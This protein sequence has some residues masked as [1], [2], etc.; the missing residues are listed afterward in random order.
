MNTSTLIR[1]A[2][3]LLPAAAKQLGGRVGVLGITNTVTMNRDGSATP[4]HT[5]E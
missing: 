4:T 2:A 3:A 5:F 1:S